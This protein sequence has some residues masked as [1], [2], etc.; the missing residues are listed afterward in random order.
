MPR[1][2]PWCPPTRQNHNRGNHSTTVEMVWTCRQN[3]TATPSMASYQ[4]DFDTPRPRERPPTRL[5]DQVQSD[6]GMPLQDAEH[7][8]QGRP[9]WRRITR[10]RAKGHT[11]LRL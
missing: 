8:A 4:H 5:R 9:E 6:L 2:H 10:K 1:I 7:Q 11:V 3:A